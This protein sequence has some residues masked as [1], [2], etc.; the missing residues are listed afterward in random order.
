MR[1]KVFTAETMQEVMNMV[2]EELGIDAV[3]L[4]T[5]RF[6]KGGVF[7]FLGKD[8]IEVTAAV[9]DKP[10]PPAEMESVVPKAI[11]PKAVVKQYAQSA[12]SIMEEPLPEEKKTSLLETDV[13]Q[14]TAP[15]PAQPLDEPSVSVQPKAEKAP[16]PPQPVASEVLEAAV[17]AVA[18]KSDVIQKATTAVAD[19]V[20]SPVVSV[21]A[22]ENVIE[23]KA[24]E[25][26]V[27]EPSQEEVKAAVV[28][29]EKAE[30]Q[31]KAV[32]VFKRRRTKRKAP[33]EAAVQIGSEKKD[34]VEEVKK[35][36]E[37]EKEK[38]K[39]KDS[40]IEH[41]Q[42]ELSDMKKMLEQVISTKAAAQPESI[43]LQKLLQDNEL[44]TEIIDEIC[45]SILDEAVLA[46][47]NTPETQDF[48]SD[49]FEKTFRPAKEIEV[50]GDKSRIVA[51][52]GAT[53]VGKTTT[54]AK[55]AAKFI[56]EKAASVALITADTYR[57]SA[58]DQL[59]T[60][61]DILNIPLEIVYAPD[62][63]KA[64][65]DKH[66]DKQLILIDTAG[67]SQHNQYQLNELKELLG[68]SADIEK[69]LV[70]SATTKYR[71]AVDI[72][73]KFAICDPD[74]VLFTKV[75]ETSS[76]GTI[77]NLAYHYPI[78]LSYLT[79]GQSVPDDIAL[80]NSE[81]LAKML[82]R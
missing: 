33:E 59:K 70:I 78:T 46:D 16:E 60:Y 61:S 37:V 43:S 73:R 4:H 63:L 12:G 19:E 35:I 2:K 26:R 66:W 39:E 34:A 77:I 71:D 50:G 75:D 55:V 47:K 17:Q 18:A 25:K 45:G 27:K 41:L 42:Q 56:L 8:M 72:L 36:P 57:I 65:I 29:E 9:E 20:P 23:E 53:G 32:R 62:E 80:G 52:I 67:R 3:I 54:I 82:L 30:P 68:V 48:L 10:Q 81:Y 22:K 44:E 58:V 5:R 13:H 40:Q 15:Q 64:A 51:F 11:V 6:H 14:E 1:I 7:G 24:A 79:N 76:I 28:V 74:K 38:E 49:Y 31:V 69:H 21:P